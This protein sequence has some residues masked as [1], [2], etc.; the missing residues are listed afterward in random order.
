M[1]IWKTIEEWTYEYFDADTPVTEFHGFEKIL[2]LWNAKRVEGSLPAWSDFDFADFRGW[3]GK[4]SKSTIFY[5]PFEY[6]IDLFGS[7]FVDLVGS[8]WTGM[9]GR[10]VTETHADTELDMKFYEMI[11]RNGLISRVS[12]SLPWEG[13]AFIEAL[14]IELPLSDDGKTVTHTLEVTR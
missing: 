9:T 14:V 3:H 13:R 1:T 6:R 5:D 11:C 4:I 10:E 8:E 7:D 2:N 12:G